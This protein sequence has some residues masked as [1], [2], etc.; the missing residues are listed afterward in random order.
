M[1]MYKNRVS[2]DPATQ[3]RRYTTL[4]VL[5]QTLRNQ[6]LRLTRV[7]TFQDPFE[8]SV[9]KRQ[10]DDQV[11]IFSGA[12]ATQMMMESVAAQ[13]PG[14]GTPRRPYRD[15]W[16][17]MTQ[18][19]RAKT[20]SAHA[21]CWSAGDESEALWRLYCRD[22][23][24]EGTGLALRSTFGQLEAPVTHHDLLV[25]AVTY[26]YYHE[27]DAFDD[28]LDPFMHKRTGFSYEREVRLLKY[29][30]RHTLILRLPLRVAMW[31]RRCH[32]NYLNISFSTGPRKA[33]LR[34]S[35][36]AHMRTSH[37]RRRQ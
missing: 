5:V 6:Q 10:I 34:R 30:E 36:S 35:Q 25:S 27:G 26:R 14:M 16:T 1:P 28:E 18:R 15:L 8:G 31:P 20:R 12:N 21:S 17:E 22:G 24:V 4:D 37:T 13:Y 32:R 2:M 3:I 23:G 9:P 29:D 19:R 7:D 33:S 11:P